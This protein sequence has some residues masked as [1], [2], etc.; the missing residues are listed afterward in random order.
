MTTLDLAAKDRGLL[1]NT[2][3]AL[4][5][6]NVFDAVVDTLGVPTV[7]PKGR[8][9]TLRENKVANVSKE[10]ARQ[11]SSKTTASS[12]VQHCYRDHNFASNTSLSIAGGTD[13]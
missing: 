12:D 4:D 5:C 2:M 11:E 8:C 6:R 7:T 10:H 9:R 1:C 3:T 13:V